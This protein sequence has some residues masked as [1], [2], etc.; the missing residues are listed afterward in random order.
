MGVFSYIYDSMAE[1]K[2][3]KSDSPENV[4]LREK[5]LIRKLE[6]LKSIYDRD[7]PLSSADL[8]LLEKHGVIE[9][10]ELEKLPE[11]Q[12]LKNRTFINEKSKGLAK[13]AD[14]HI[15]I[16][17]VSVDQ[18][19][20]EEEL[21]KV[22]NEK[23]FSNINDER[24]TYKGGKKITSKDWLPESR[25]YHERDFVEWIDSINSG[26]Q[27][28]VHYDK[29]K[30]Y[31]QQSEDWMKDDSSIYDYEDEDQRREWAWTEMERMK[32][33]SLYFLDKYL[34]VKESGYDG[35]FMKYVARPVHKVMA[36][37]MDSGY[38]VEMGKGRQIAATTTV[39]GL[40][41]CRTMTR[42]NFFIKM[43]AQDKDKVKEIFDD[44]IK[45]PH[46]E[47]PDWL[48][49]EPKNDTEELL[50][51]GKKKTKGRISGANSKIQVVAPTV[52]AINGGAPPLVLIDEGGYIGILGK[53]IK[54]ARPTMFM[55]DQKTGKIAMKRQIWIW[56][57]G[58][59]MDKKGK[60]YEEEYRNTF[61]KWQKRDFTNGIIPLFFDWTTRPG[62]TKEHFDNEKRAYTVEG[63]DSEARMVQ[64][65]QTY[66]AIIEDMFLTSSKTLVSIAYINKRLE[67]IRN[68][69]HEQREE[70][71]FFEPKYDTTKPSQ[72]HDDLPYKLVGAEF[73]R[74][75]KDDPRAS[76]RIFFRPEKGWIDRYYSG[77]DP[78]ANDNGWSNMTNSIW[79]AHMNTLSA[80][81]NYRSEDHKYTFLQTLCLS[82]YYDAS[83]TGGDKIGVPTL[84]ESNIGTAFSDYAEYKGYERML[85]LNS[86]LQSSFVGGK[87]GIGIDNRGQRNQ[88]IISKLYELIMLY[89]DRI[90][91]EDF[92]KQ[93]TTFIC[94]ISDKGNESWGTQDPRKYHDD[95]LF[96]TVFAYI[97]AISFAYKPPRN[98]KRKEDS[99]VVE[100]E[101]QRVNGELRRVPVKRKIT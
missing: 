22:L 48:F 98:S 1:E 92:W 43:I 86:E 74:T 100:Y 80:V 45:W 13:K 83:R 12:V 73:V 58:G 25:I 94:T 4:A 72:E 20:K 28:M 14:E 10:K 76:V 67:F 56:G 97:C 18:Y 27:K 33:N 59:E 16:V 31:C 2:K 23:V 71:G 7:I 70:Y 35:G 79:D 88:F 24:F 19:K 82:I 63:P 53:M 66:P 46:S 38:N 78:I 91:I 9:K 96:S 26:F 49:Q 37:L 30:M 17:E 68:L 75:T 52:S 93:L 15:D 65:R 84:L 3:K 99:Y 64:F 44:K 50:H 51:L 6:Y 29:F 55:M 81:V 21:S 85:V 101:L 34:K 41:L 39:A 47:M 36:F 61:E 32:E 8:S 11:E 87:N 5:K 95:T 42:K 40:A 69:D 77:I 62:I 54:E 89:G 60:A 90:F 57:T